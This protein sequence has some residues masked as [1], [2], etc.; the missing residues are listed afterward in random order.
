MTQAGLEY[1]LRHPLHGKPCGMGLAHPTHA[2]WLQGCARHVGGK[3]ID[4]PADWQALID[5]AEVDLGPIEASCRVS[6]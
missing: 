1:L 5:E 2:Y 6:S 4:L 3:T